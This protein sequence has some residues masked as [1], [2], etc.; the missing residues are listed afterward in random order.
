M[1]NESNKNDVLNKAQNVL[2]LSYKKFRK[3]KRIFIALSLTSLCISAATIILNLYAIRFN[4]YP[5]ELMHLFVAISIIGV[6]VSFI[7]SVQSF[8]NFS[9]EKYLLKEKIENNL[10]TIKKIEEND[11]ADVEDL[12]ERLKKL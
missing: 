12:D 11:T 4:I 3:S 1:T 10:E 6:L 5:V 2:K 7:V 8:F 9:N